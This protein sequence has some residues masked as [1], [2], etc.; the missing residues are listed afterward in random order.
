MDRWIDKQD[1]ILNPPEPLS[2]T[3]YNLEAATPGNP[4]AFGGV[5]ADI[6]VEAAQPFD[7]LLDAAEVAGRVFKFG[8]LLRNRT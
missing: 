8:V 5:Y 2:P 1:P 4:Q 7:R 3:A 6:D